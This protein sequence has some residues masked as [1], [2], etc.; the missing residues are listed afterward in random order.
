MSAVLLRQQRSAVAGHCGVR[1]LWFR[2]Y[3]PSDACPRLL[4]LPVLFHHA[5]VLPLHGSFPCED[6]EEGSSGWAKELR[7]APQPEPLLS[8][9]PGCR[10]VPN[11]VLAWQ[12]QRLTAL[13]KHQWLTALKK[14]Q[15]LTF[16]FI[17]SYVNA[18]FYC[19]E[20]RLCGDY[21]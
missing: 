16:G 11:A 17:T 2:W 10:A 1:W 20:K 7:E 21:C 19:T 12:H 6:H 8:A 18:F 14:H 15:R 13:K 9:L 3:I 4:E 5:M